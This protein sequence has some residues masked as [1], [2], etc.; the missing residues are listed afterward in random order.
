MNPKYIA[1]DLFGTV[2]D[3]HSRPKEEFEPYGKLLEEYK[4]GIWKP[5]PYSA[6]WERMKPFKD[7]GIGLAAL[8][9]KG[10]RVVAL[11]NASMRLT[12]EMSSNAEIVWDAIIPLEAIKVYKPDVRAYEFALQLLQCIPAEM[13]MVSANKNFGDIETAKSIG[14]QAKLIRQPGTGVTIYDLAKSLPGRV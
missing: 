9:A 10:Y 1:F 2:L 4:N 12:I 8:Q 13:M 5:F 6:H 11:S 14:C 3:A 7:S